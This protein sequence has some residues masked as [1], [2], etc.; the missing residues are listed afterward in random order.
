MTKVFVVMKDLSGFFFIREKGKKCHKQLDKL[1]LIY[2]KVGLFLDM[3]LILMAL[4]G[5]SIFIKHLKDTR[6]Q[7][8][9]FDDLTQSITVFSIWYRNF[10]YAMY[11]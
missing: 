1:S 4:D 7:Q 10:I 6:W 2:S 5:V 3:I 9:N 11:G 8:N